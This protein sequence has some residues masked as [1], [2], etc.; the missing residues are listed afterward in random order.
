M[1]FSDT[2][3]LVTCALK[4][5]LTVHLLRLNDTPLC[6]QH[7]NFVTSTLQLFCN[8]NMPSCLAVS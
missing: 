4:R 6:F 3:Q 2:G 8:T 1:L 7:V 5:S